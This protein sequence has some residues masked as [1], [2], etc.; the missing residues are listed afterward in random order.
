MYI[1]ANQSAESFQLFG[2]IVQ[3]CKI[4]QTTAHL[5]SISGFWKK[6]TKNAEKKQQNPMEFP[7]DFPA[8]GVIHLEGIF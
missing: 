6:T 7:V 8:A 4:G 5:R 1:F 3:I 2:D